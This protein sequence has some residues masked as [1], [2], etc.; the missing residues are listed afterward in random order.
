MRQ[1]KD[2]ILHSSPN[3]DDSD[4]QA[5]L[6]VMN[7]GHLESGEWVGTLEQ[8]V[9]KMLKR[10]H[11]VA[12]SSGFAAIHLS[13][14]A[15]GIGEG[16]EVI[17]PSYSCPAL[18]NPVKIVG[19][20]PIIVDIGENSFNLVK[21]DVSKAL[22]PNVKAIIVPHMFG[23]PANI[24]AI[25]TLG[26]P[27][28]EDCAHSLGGRIDERY[29]GSEGDLTI[30][31]FYSSKMICGG[32]GGMV[33]T[34]DEALYLA[35]D[36]YRYYGKKKRHQFLAYNYE[37][38]NLQAALALSQLSRVDEFI[39]KRRDIA[40]KYDSFL[41]G[42]SSIFLD[43]EEKESSVYYRYPI[44]IDKRDEIKN[45][46]RIQGVTSGF[47]V[48]E[49]LHQIWNASAGLECPNTEL[50]L[51]QILSLP[52]YPSMKEENVERVCTLL[53]ENLID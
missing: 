42:Q 46:L 35:L 48:L 21:K 51:S 39:G 17:I 31:S 25:K 29:L 22:T 12:V 44:R 34:D 52:I 19:A 53:L 36:N 10:K 40:A 49:G 2:I 8:N 27:V 1:E 6:D 18:L 24:G 3:I 37:L 9:A 33:V 50:M 20:T 38:G 5:V 15:L 47:G 13:L 11:A 7:S 45:N 41:K 43:F 28:I 32:N 26:I 23:F 16:D 30:L 4:I 14:I